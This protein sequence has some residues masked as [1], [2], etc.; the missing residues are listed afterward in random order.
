MSVNST[1]YIEKVHNRQIVQVPGSKLKGSYVKEAMQSQNAS[2][3]A[4]TVWWMINAW[5]FNLVFYAG[6]MCLKTGA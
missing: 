4:G 3:G 5:S 1:I 2:M 6:V